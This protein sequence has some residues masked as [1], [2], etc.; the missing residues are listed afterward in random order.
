MTC[1]PWSAVVGVTP[2]S[3]G[4]AI[5]SV[6]RGP[7]PSQPTPSGATSRHVTERHGGRQQ[8]PSRDGVHHSSSCPIPSDARPMALVGLVASTSPTPRPEPRGSGLDG[9]GA[10]APL[11]WRRVQ[12]V[13]QKPC[14]TLPCICCIVLTCH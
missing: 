10:R 12:A 4:Q 9:Q 7:P 3:S 6:T 5:W 2:S 8:G 11:R 14:N 13:I 1:M